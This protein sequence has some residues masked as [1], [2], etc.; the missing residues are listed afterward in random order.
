MNLLDT[1][2]NEIYNA[3]ILTSE[4]KNFF[5]IKKI[6]ES[7]LNYLYYMNIINDYDIIINNYK[8]IVEFMFNDNNKK[9]RKI[10]Y[11]KRKTKLKQ[12][13]K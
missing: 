10:T 8:I 13:L 1:T 6:I 7:N 9:W 5:T 4:E 2:K 3:L 11:N 12:L